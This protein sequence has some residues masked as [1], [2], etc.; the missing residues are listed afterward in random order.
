VPPIKE[1]FKYNIF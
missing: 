1:P